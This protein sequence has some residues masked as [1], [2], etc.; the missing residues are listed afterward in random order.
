MK[1]AVF[2]FIGILACGNNLWGQQPA[3]TAARI[4]WLERHVFFNPGSTEAVGELAGLYEAS[5]DYNRAVQWYGLLSA[6]SGK[7]GFDAGIA[8]CRIH[9]KHIVP[10]GA[11]NCYR[12]TAGM[13]KSSHCK[14]SQQL[15]RIRFYH[16]LACLQLEMYEE[17]T[18]TAVLLTDSAGAA[19][20]RK[21]AAG[22]KS[23]FRS[24]EKAG[25]RSLFPGAGQWYA[26]DKRN[27][28]NAFVLN[29]GIAGISYVEFRR[30]PF[31]GI[32]LFAQFF[33]RYYKG[34]IINARKSA[35]YANNRRRNEFRR[36]VLNR[37]SVHASGD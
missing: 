34:N 1:R 31:L 4:R 11:L 8:A 18:V 15:N 22:L 35:V 36:I 20:I 24:P 37:V 12:I 6:D 14:D 30:L 28:V 2:F 7:A 5:G 9:L 23:S 17:A 3:D 26:G 21:A 25:R 29:A 33:P 10:D 32:A 16:L 27:A 19:E 13:M